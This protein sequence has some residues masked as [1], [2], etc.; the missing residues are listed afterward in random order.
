MSA[1]LALSL[2]N[3]RLDSAADLVSWLRGEAGLEPDQAAE[4]A[5]R[6]AEFK[7]LRSCLLD[8]VGAAGQGR[9]LPDDAVGRL[10]EISARVPRVARLG[11][12]GSSLEPIAASG[13]PLLL[14]EIAWSAIGLLGGPDRERLRRCPA[15]GMI[16]VATRPDRLWC[17]DRC[18]NRIRVARHHARMRGPTYPVRG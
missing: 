16:F 7:E 9:P 17:S 4:L 2:S 14:A 8:L 6:L 10:N 5:L 1:A 18:G 13:A 15:C 11:G 3:A 12:D